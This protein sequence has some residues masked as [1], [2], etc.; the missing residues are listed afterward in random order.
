[1]KFWK[2]KE[3]KGKGREEC[4][5]DDYDEEKEKRRNDQFISL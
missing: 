2:L 3:E 1:M 5:N 4:S